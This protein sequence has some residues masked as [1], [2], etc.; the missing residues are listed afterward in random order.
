V[1]RRSVATRHARKPHRE[2]LEPAEAPRGLGQPR[3]TSRSLFHRS[4]VQR[5]NRHVG[6]VAVVTFRQFRKLC[7]SMPEA[8]EL[9][10][11]GEATFRVRGRIFAMGSSEGSSVSV[12]ASLDDQSGL[13]AMD[14]KTVAVWAHT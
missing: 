10:T 9:E 6:T 1:E 14:A 2:V 11:W 5:L 3:L 4:F 7:L 12:M 13:V 8:E